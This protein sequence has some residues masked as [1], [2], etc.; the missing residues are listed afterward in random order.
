MTRSERED[1][2]K[3]FAREAIEREKRNRDQ[4][5]RASCFMNAATAK[6]LEF[7]NDRK[8]LDAFIKTVEGYAEEALRWK[9][10]NALEDLSAARGTIR[11][12]R[13]EVENARADLAS[14]IAAYEAAKV[15]ARK[16]AARLRSRAK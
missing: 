10:G 13:A 11:M 15:R 1:A 12:L 14:T 5:A 16:R 8:R 3:A 6:Q 4:G 2:R 9:L 7:D